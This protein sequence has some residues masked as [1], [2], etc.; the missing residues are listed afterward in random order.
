MIMARAARPDHAPSPT[1]FDWPRRQ[2]I[3]ELA[4]R[5][6]ELKAHIA[7]L[8]PR[9]HACVVAKHRLSEIT[10]ELLAETV[11]L[12]AAIAPPRTLQ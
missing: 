6:A 1:L 9:S 12:R 2:R 10:R 5:R 4:A 7:T 3:D 8:K 11:E